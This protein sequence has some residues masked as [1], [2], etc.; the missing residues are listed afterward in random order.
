MYLTRRY[1]KL[2]I[3]TLPVVVA[4]AVLAEI[5]GVNRIKI[6]LYQIS[7]ISHKISILDREL[8]MMQKEN[9]DLLIRELWGTLGSELWGLTLRNSGV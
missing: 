2:I 1:F 3:I 6:T 5:S 9:N 4:F 7:D 8:A